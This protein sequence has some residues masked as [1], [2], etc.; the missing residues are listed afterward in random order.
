MVNKGKEKGESNFE[1]RVSDILDALEIRYSRDV[2]VFSYVLDNRAI[3]F[4]PDFIIEDAKINNKTVLLEPHGKAFFTDKFIN[5][6]RLFKESDVSRD[7]YLILITDSKK[8]DLK[9]RLNNFSSGPLKL[10]DICDEL[11]V[12]GKTKEL[13]ES[14]H[15][16]EALNYGLLRRVNP[17]V[18]YSRI[19]TTEY[20]ENELISRLLEVA[21]PK[22]KGKYNGIERR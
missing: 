11:I 12:E 3:T 7:Y 1:R 16:S 21:E 10:H 15:E 6:L 13:F 2:I 14:S 9:R 19:G 18:I 5:K 17:Q 4:T 20:S 8:G 22:R